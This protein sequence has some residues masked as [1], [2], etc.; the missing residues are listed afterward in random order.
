MTLYRT[1]ASPLGDLLLTGVPDDEAPGGIRL[2]SLSTPGQR[3]A[4]AVGDG[5]RHD[6]GAFTAVTDQLDAYFAGRLHSFDV[7]LTVTGTPFQQRVWAAL[8]T[9]GYGTT[10]TYGAL[11]TRIGIPPSAARALGAAIG[12]NP[13]LVIRPCHRVIGANGALTG[14][15]G[16]LGRKQVLLELEG[17]AAAVAGRPAGA[18]SAARTAGT[19]SARPGSA[20]PHG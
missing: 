15:A 16:G 18:V 5:W 19:A 2:A 9:I 11:A 6:P 7:A 14:Y 20:G 10:T 8:E 17:P 3:S 13:V 4:P 1:F 12:A